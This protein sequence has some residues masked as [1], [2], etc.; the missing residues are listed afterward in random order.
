MPSTPSAC[1]PSAWQVDDL[2]A[3]FLGLS[4]SKDAI[5][6]RCPKADTQVEV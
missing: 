5:L 3:H 2:V 6:E 1:C 4:I